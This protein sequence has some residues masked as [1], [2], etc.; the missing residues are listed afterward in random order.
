MDMYPTCVRPTMAEDLVEKARAFVRSYR[1]YGFFRQA[2]DE[3]GERAAVARIVEAVSN[4]GVWPED[5]HLVQDGIYWFD[6]EWV[7]DLDRMYTE[8]LGE[9]GG[10]SGGNLRFENVKEVNEFTDPEG[11]AWVEFDWRGERH[12]IDLESMGDYID[13]PA[14]VKY[15]NDRLEAAGDPHRVVVPYDTGD[16]TA[17]LAY[18][19][20]DAIRALRDRGWAITLW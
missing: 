7:G 2:A 1:A 15:I 17:V 4:G 3:A 13:A 20:Q 18:L 19:T 12:H 6:T 10:L 11:P 16:Q 5:W 14:V 8:F 9:L